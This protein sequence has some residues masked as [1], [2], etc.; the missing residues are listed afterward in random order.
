MNAQIRNNQ[1]P[2]YNTSDLFKMALT[3]NPINFPVTFPA[4][5]GDTH[6]RFGNAILSGTNLRTNPYAYM[7]SSYKQMQENTLNTSLKISQ[8]LD[9]ITKGLSATAL[10][11]FKTGRPTGITVPSSPTTT[12]LKTEV[13]ILLRENTPWKDWA[14]AE[15][16]ISHS[17][18]SPKTA[19]TL[20]SCSLP[21]TISA[22]S[23]NTA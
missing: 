5:E 13:S 17:R 14:Q 7:L 21:S 12:A 2:N 18:I 3:T 6:I 8:Q 15:Q 4:Q 9:F 1:G 19:T 16:I 22:V 23:A 11:N 20:S 10:I